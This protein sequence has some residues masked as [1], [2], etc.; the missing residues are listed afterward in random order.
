MAVVANVWLIRNSG[1]GRL[2]F[3]LGFGGMTLV[4][5]CHAFIVPPMGFAADAAAVAIVVCLFIDAE[6]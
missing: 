6:R 1:L 5:V 4:L 3:T 2:L